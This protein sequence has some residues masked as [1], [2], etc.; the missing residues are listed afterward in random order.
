MIDGRRAFLKLLAGLPFMSASLLRAEEKKSAPELPAERPA[1]YLFNIF[2]IAGFQYYEGPGLIRRIRTG[3]LLLLKAEPENPHDAFAVRVE[4]RGRMLGY[5]PRSDNRH[6]RRLLEQGAR[7]CC[8][9]VEVD[10]EAPPWNQLRVEVMHD[11]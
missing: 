8:R 7:L 3:E 5:V 4:R 6:I 10:R 2:S 1:S 11:V 9:V